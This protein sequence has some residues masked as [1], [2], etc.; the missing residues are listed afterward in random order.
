[1]GKFLPESHGSRSSG[2]NFA[3]RWKHENVRLVLLSAILSIAMTFMLLVLLYG[4][5][6]KQVSVV[7]DGEERI[8]TTKQWVLEKLLDELDI[9]VGPNDEVSKPLNA[10]IRD[11]DRIVINQA[12]PVT[13]V[14]D[15]KA[16]EVWPTRHTVQAALSEAGIDLR[17]DDKVYPSPGA[18][19][20]PDMTIEVVRVDKHVV[21]TEEVVPYEVVKKDDPNLEKGKEKV[22][23]PGKE[24][25]IINLVEK[26]FENGVYVNSRLLTKTVS[27]EK[28]DQ[29]VAVG[30]KKPEPKAAVLSAES[31][32]AT[33]VTREGVTFKAKKVLKNVTLT[34]YSAGF[35]STGKTEDHPQYGITASGTKV[36][37]GRTI[38]VDP[39]VIPLGWWVYIEGIGF[40]RA[41]DKGSAVKGKKID[42]YYDSETKAERFG[43]KK[44]YTVYVIGP[45]KPTAS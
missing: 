5:A 11:G 12:V 44:G 32:T 38:A 6:D 40:R 13:V 34:A 43:K 30:T 31:E 45:N 39:D 20:E 35:E 25:V 4:T 41:E 22:I 42:I 21:Q 23:Q 19:L 14:A 1:M 27:A 17:D 9:E 2:M 36:Q 15:G 18:P 29:I 8:V 7:V 37:E 33:K 10:A 28:Q 3:M 26:T 16:V 24:G